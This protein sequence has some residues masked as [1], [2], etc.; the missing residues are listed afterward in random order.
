MKNILLL[1]SIV[2]TS[3]MA[4]AGDN[5]F[6]D[7]CRSASGRT[8]LVVGHV[9]GYDAGESVQLTIDGKSLGQLVVESSVLKNEIDENTTR[10]NE[11]DH[12]G[13]DLVTIRRL[14]LTPRDLRNDTSTIEILSGEDPRTNKPLEVQI[15]V[16]C[17]TVYN[18]I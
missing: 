9:G 2:L 18:P 3:V 11:A 5:G 16:T 6:Y 17:K 10:Y 7:T 4:Q 13:L 15:L 14:P 8:Q 1:T 12:D